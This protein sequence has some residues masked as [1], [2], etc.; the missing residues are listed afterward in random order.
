MLQ[1]IDCYRGNYELFEKAKTEK[2]KNQQREIEAQM[3]QRQHV[4]E[5]IDKFRYNAN[6]ASSVQSKIKMLEKMPELKPIEKEPEVVLKFP[7]VD[8][9]SPPIIQIDE[10]GFRYSPD[11]PIIF[12]DVNL[13][14]N[15]DSRICIVSVILCQKLLGVCE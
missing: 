1:R 7:D 6:R 2:L 5:F 11:T 13:G 15:L 4:Q 8:S 12:Q 14:A 3:G 10:A 9:L